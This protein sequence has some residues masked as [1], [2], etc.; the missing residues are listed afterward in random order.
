MF[1]LALYL[2]SFAAKRKM[3][4]TIFMAQPS[5]IFLCS[6]LLSFFFDFTLI[7]VVYMNMGIKLKEEYNIGL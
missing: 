2:I 1:C 6:H 7:N 4:E 5:L 3:V